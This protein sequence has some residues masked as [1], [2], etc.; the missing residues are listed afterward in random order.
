MNK[1]MDNG[2]LE[3]PI[4]L[5]DNER[6]RSLSTDTVQPAG[7]F[8]S[9][10]EDLW[11]RDKQKKILLPFK[12][13]RAG[14]KNKDYPFAFRPGEV[15]LWAGKNGCG[16]SLLTG[17]I[18]LFLA[19][20]KQKVCIA[21]FEIAP[22]ITLNRM[23]RQVILTTA[24]EYTQDQVTWFF[25]NINPYLCLYSREGKVT[26]QDVLN[27]IYSGYVNYGCTHFFI[28]S[29]TMC[30]RL[31]D[32]NGQEEF[33]QL[34][35]SIAKSLQVHVNLV[36]HMRKAKTVDSRNFNIYDEVNQDN[37][38]GTGAIS[39][40]AFNV[41]TMTSNQ[42]KMLKRKIGEKFDD[43]EPDLLIALTKHRLGNWMGHIPLWYD[44]RSMNFCETNDRN[45]RT[46][47]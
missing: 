46:I 39:D 10:L 27:L 8:R 41:F 29:L 5:H 6:L 33:M 17:Q 2:A 25:K 43:N 13:Q 12:D 1:L 32:Y 3:N 19:A 45:P 23:I 28:D 15:T 4:T 38:R 26:P 18:A 36:A 44:A 22:E 14:Y 24:K 9:K 37:I 47:F 35:T 31:D 34:L 21:S 16:K 40:L 30:T 42:K 7:A 20:Q 11:E